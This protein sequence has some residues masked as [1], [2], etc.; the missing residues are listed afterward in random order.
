M[1][2]FEDDFN[3]EYDKKYDDKKYDEIKFENC[4]EKVVER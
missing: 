2:D 4:D 3:Y 1:S